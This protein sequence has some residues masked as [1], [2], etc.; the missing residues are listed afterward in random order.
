MDEILFAIETSGIYSVGRFVYSVILY[1]LLMA[2]LLFFINGARYYVRLNREA[3]ERKER[4]AKS[5]E[6]QWIR[7]QK[8]EAMRPEE[9]TVRKVKSNSVFEE[10]LAAFKEE[11]ANPNLTITGRKPGKPEPQWSKPA[12]PGEIKKILEGVR[13]AD[14]SGF[15]MK[16]EDVE[17]SPGDVRGAIYEAQM[18]GFRNLNEP[19]KFEGETNVV[20][21]DHMPVASYPVEGTDDPEETYKNAVEKNDD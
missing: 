10:N 9:P 11:M 3:A 18:E 20:F 13:S 8:I 4:L 7:D 15:T 16:P 19:K 21:S 6:K 14:Y 2:A 12:K 5:A 17:S 1:M